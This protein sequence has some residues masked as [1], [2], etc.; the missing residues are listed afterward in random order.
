MPLA[1]V[2]SKS[3]QGFVTVVKFEEVESVLRNPWLIMWDTITDGVHVAV[4]VL[5]TADISPCNPSAFPSLCK[6][7]R[8]S[9]CQGYLYL[10]L[11]LEELF[12]GRSGNQGKKGLE[13]KYTCTE[14]CAPCTN[15]LLCALWLHLPMFNKV[16]T[17]VKAFPAIRES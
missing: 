17:Q 1:S 13:K 5:S 3:L 4:V 2:N 16:W 15:K 14:S 8:D 6:L 11:L 9:T 7:T 12:L 10:W